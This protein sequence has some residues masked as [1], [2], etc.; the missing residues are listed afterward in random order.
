[1]MRTFMTVSKVLSDGHP[2]KNCGV[3]TFK[4]RISRDN[5]LILKQKLQNSKAAATGYLFRCQ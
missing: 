1:M 5:F 4:T 3:C 2:N